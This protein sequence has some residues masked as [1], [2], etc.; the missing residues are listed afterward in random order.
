MQNGIEVKVRSNE[1]TKRNRRVENE[2]KKKCVDN[3]TVN[4]EKIKSIEQ[5]FKQKT[6]ST[7]YETMTEIQ[8]KE[9]ILKNR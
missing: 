9:F 8:F 2:K 7:C 6:E 1:N 4:D 3:T 5:Y